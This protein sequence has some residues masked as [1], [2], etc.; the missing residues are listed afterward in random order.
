MDNKLQQLYIDLKSKA[1]PHN[2]VNE[3]WLSK[4]LDYIEILEKRIT[5]LEQLSPESR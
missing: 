5:F 1:I 2:Q 3:L 4:L